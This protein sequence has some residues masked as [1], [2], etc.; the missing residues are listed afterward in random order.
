MP[1]PSSATEPFAVGSSSSL[2]DAI[3][4]ASFTF[5]K[6]YIKGYPLNSN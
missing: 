6:Y 3:N 1:A 4:A 2:V 5:L